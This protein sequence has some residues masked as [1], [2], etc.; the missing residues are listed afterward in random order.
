MKL[1]L[2]H[3]RRMRDYMLVYHDDELVFIGRTD[4]DF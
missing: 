3:L 2:K 4:S 1:I